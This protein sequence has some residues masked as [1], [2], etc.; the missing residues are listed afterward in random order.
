M[1]I[2]YIQDAKANDELNITYKDHQKFC[3][4][5]EN[6]EQE[7]SNEHFEEDYD[8]N[9]LFRFKTA[10]IDN[11]NLKTIQKNLSLFLKKNGYDIDYLLKKYDYKYYK[12]FCLC[13]KL[14][15]YHHLKIQTAITYDIYDYV[16]NN[17]DKEEFLKIWENIDTQKKKKFKDMINSIT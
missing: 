9:Y 8:A 6:L 13:K 5:K 10:S 12:L 2:Y 3:Y 17:S 14:Y 16:K 4:L 1:P 11:M 15:S 7:K